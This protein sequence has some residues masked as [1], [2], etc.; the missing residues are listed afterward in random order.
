M[1]HHRRL[2]VLQSPRGRPR[3]FATHRLRVRVRVGRV[4]ERLIFGGIPVLAHAQRNTTIL[5]GIEELGAEDAD[6]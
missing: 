3:L 1:R 6:R 2:V 5:V 4:E